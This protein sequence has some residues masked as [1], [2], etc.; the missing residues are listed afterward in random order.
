MRDNQLLLLRPAI[1]ID[2]DKQSLDIENF[3]NQTLRPILK[4]QNEVIID[5]VLNHINKDEIPLKEKDKGLF[6]KKNFQ[7]NLV[8]KN[9]LIGLTIG[10]F[11]KMEFTFYLEN[12]TEINKRINQLLIKRILDQI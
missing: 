1:T 9:Q 11:S 8:L 2:I 6:I 7:K 3:Q 5:L 4:F 10:L 12:K